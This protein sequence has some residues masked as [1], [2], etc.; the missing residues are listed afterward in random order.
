VSGQITPLPKLVKETKRLSKAYYDSIGCEPHCSEAL[1]LAS[2][3]GDELIDELACIAFEATGAIMRIREAKARA[4][5][6]AS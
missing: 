3:E 6:G 1:D 5:E 2:P 4:A